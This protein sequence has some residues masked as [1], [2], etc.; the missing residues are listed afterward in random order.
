MKPKISKPTFIAAI[1]V[2]AVVIAIEASS[3]A[4]ST[5]SA[6]DIIQTTQM[7]GNFLGRT[8]FVYNIIGRRAGFTSITASN[9]IKEFDNAVANFPTITTANTLEIVSTSANDTAAGTGIRTVRVVYIDG[10]NNLV[11]SAAIPLNGVTPVAAGF[12]ANEIIWMESASFGT[13]P[14]IAAGDIV[15]RVV[16]GP[17]PVEQISTGRGKSLSAKFMVPTGYTGF[18]TLFRGSSINQ[19]Q[20]L[21]LLA[22]ENTFN[23]SLGLY[24]AMVGGTIALNT[25]SEQSLAFI[26][27]PALARIKAS[28]ISAGTSAAVRA[29]TS[30]TVI[31]ISD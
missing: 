7:R 6:T 2:V 10:S 16:A 17:V 4:V 12:T 11:Q 1:L 29:E 28:T 21:K 5:I 18:L 20:D 15:L 3:T 8:A 25:S 26:K 31:L 13:P 30:F 9:D 27:V 14:A 19:D 23:G 22:Q 24:H